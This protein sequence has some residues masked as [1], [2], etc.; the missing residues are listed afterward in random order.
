M[1]QRYYWD[2]E[3][4]K[5]LYATPSSL[6]EEPASDK[7]GGN[8]WLKDDTVYLKLDY[9]KKYTDIDSYIEQDPAQDCDTVQIYQ[10]GDR[11]REERYRDPLPGRDQGADPFQTGEEYSSPADE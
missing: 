9:V 1:N 11:D 7:A 6:T 5:I 2:S 4:K 8:V 3:N 10:C